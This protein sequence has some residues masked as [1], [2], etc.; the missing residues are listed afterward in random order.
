LGKR[1]LSFQ[2]VFWAT[3][4]HMFHCLIYCM[5]SSLKR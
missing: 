3:L 2:A 1:L 4:K 5:L